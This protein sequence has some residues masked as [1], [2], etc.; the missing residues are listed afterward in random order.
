[1][2]LL[3]CCYPLLPPH[4]SD[5]GGEQVGEPAIRTRVVAYTA[6]GEPWPAMFRSTPQHRVVMKHTTSDF[7]ARAMTR[8]DE[9]SNNNNNNGYELPAASAASFHQL[10]GKRHVK[11]RRSMSFPTLI[12]RGTYYSHLYCNVYWTIMRR[13]SQFIKNH[14]KVDNI[15]FYPYVN[16]S[17]TEIFFGGSGVNNNYQCYYFL[18]PKYFIN[19]SHPND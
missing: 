4:G 7:T 6:G 17:M 16:T 11:T 14:R 1:V 3:L 13:L 12:R 18:F 9:D 8:P 10:D 2:L 5:G 15:V 19:V